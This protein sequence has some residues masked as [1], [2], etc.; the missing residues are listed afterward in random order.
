[1]SIKI[2]FN[3]FIKFLNNNRK[4]ISILFLLFISYYSAYLFFT[5][6]LNWII[7]I[8]LAGIIFYLLKFF[9]N[10]PLKKSSIFYSIYLPIIIVDLSLFKITNLNFYLIFLGV[11]S[12]LILNEYL[13]KKKNYN[14]EDEQPLPLFEARKPKLIE[15][16]N[17]I[18][19]QNIP[20]IVINQK[21]GSGKTIFVKNL[22]YD[23][24]YLEMKQ[25][26]VEV[27]YIKLPFL[28]D[29]KEL[30]T[31]LLEELKKIFSK[32]KLNYF[33]LDNILKYVS[34]VKTSNFEISFT[35]KNDTFWNT[36]FKLKQNLNK[37][38]KSKH[39][40]V[41]IDDIERCPDQEF[42]KNSIFFLGEFAEFFRETKATML[43]LV[44]LKSITNDFYK[45]DIH[46]D[47][48]FSYELELPEINIFNFEKS[49]FS[50]LYTNKS[51]EDL[52]RYV[53]C[54]FRLWKKFHLE[55]LGDN[56]DK[57]NNIEITDETKDKIKLLQE[58]T[59]KKNTIRTIQKFI[60]ELSSLE[61]NTDIPLIDRL[62]LISP[63]F[64][65]NFYSINVGNLNLK[66][67]IEL[68]LNNLNFISKEYILYFYINNFSKE[69]NF[70]SNQ[71]E[72]LFK[73]KQIILN[74]SYHSKFLLSPTSLILQYIYGK[75]SSLNI[76]N[77]NLKNINWKV[78]FNAIE[79]N[80]QLNRILTINYF[81]DNVSLDLSF[82]EKLNNLLK[83]INLEKET[84]EILMKFLSNKYNLKQHY[85]LHFRY[86]VCE[87]EDE[88]QSLTLSIRAT[89]FAELHLL[90]KRQ[91]NKNLINEYS[92]YL[93]DLRKFSSN[94]NLYCEFYDQDY[95]DYNNYNDDFDS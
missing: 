10:L 30:Q 45:S 80:F 12:L 38:M 50:L 55:I 21:I 88:E 48:Y 60:N 18:F 77:K 15:L 65:K 42:R 31:V 64:L 46:F 51:K 56:L 47:K 36:L 28:N 24:E 44:D 70:F 66:K 32:N 40:L 54:F 53:D 41:I 6:K 75:T 2:Q 78:L 86:P 19:D 87:E 5:N 59:L 25:L 83:S 71:D 20:S 49:D 69:N 7:T 33:F 95:Y 94:M 43:F 68:D 89:R 82:F 84:L 73:I 61:L 34:G 63:I 72:V 22:I 39:I 26:P 58:F 27:I 16:K 67:I 29:I 35:K 92:S 23:L 9:P 91:L 4:N 57:Y 8:N 37:L 11:Y 79:N 62:I 14:Y 13:Y 74:K 90:L 85:F 93:E 52:F 17:K 76:N 1:M 3:S 81:F